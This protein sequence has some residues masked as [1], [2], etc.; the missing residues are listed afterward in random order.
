MNCAILTISDRCYNKLKD[1]ETGPALRE[2]V[3]NQ[4]WNVTLLEVIPDE[5]EIITEKLLSLAA[6]DFDI[7]VTNGGTGVGPRDITPEATSE[8]IEKEIPGMAEIMR[9]ENYN[10]TK[11]SVLSRG[12][13]GVLRN[14]LIINLPGSTKGA[15]ENLRV[16][17]PL[18][19]HTVSVMKGSI[20][21]CKEDI[22]KDADE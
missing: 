8:I 4:D 20:T 22:S 19:S 3:E 15:L 6:K 5:K 17:I 13:C 11:F 12:K 16:I 14:T 10:K 21:D 2:A 1:D 7:V 9:L 18:L